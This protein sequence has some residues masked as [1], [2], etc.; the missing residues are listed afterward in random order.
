MGGASTRVVFLVLDGMPAPAVAANMTPVLDAW[1][2]ASGTT[3]HSVPS[4][5]PASTYPNHATFVTGVAPSAH[6]IVGNHVLDADGRFRAAREIGPAVPTIFDAA[7]AAGRTSALVVGDQELVGVMGGTRASSHWPPNGA[8]PNGA[9]IDDH[10]Y[11][12]DDET[13]PVLLAAI[14]SDVDLVVGHLNAPDTAGHVHG[15][16]SETARSTYL[17]TDARLE[18]VRAT[19]EARPDQSVVVVVSDHATEA[20]D[21]DEPID[22]SAALEGTGLTWFPEGSAALVY[23]DRPDIDAVLGDIAEVE[24]SAEVAP[25]VR[26]V[27]GAP[28]RWMCF[29]GVGAE[30]GMHGSPRTAVQLAAVVGTHAAVREIDG[31]VGTAGFDAT[32]WAGELSRLLVLP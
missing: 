7:N 17:A 6:G 23:G 5:L 19:V 28:G 22:L 8:V 3:P 2:A 25:G 32:S 13:L 18:A 9:S 15:P 24:G 31:R 21:V 27:W 10:G 16:T 4:V 11:L 12:D 20:I 30:P 14:A 29:A 1:C 26:V